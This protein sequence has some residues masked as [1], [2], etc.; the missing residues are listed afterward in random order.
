MTGFEEYAALVRELS[1]RQRGGERAVAAEADRRRGLHA[2]VDQLGHRLAAQGQRLD[3]LG[4]AAG[5]PTP[6]PDGPLVPP[7]SPDGPASQVGVAPAPGAAPGAAPAPPGGGSPVPAPPGGATTT[8]GAPGSLPGTGPVATGGEAAAP[9]RPGV[10]AYPAGT[11]PAPR[12]AEVDPA[13]ELAAARQLVDEA[14]RYGQQAEALAHRSALLPTWSPPARA[15]AVYAVCSLVGS[16]LMLAALMGS[17]I[18]ATGLDLVAAVSCA[19]VPLLSFLAGQLVLGRWGRPPI[20]AGTPPSRYVP[21]GFV[22]CALVSPSLFCVYLLAF[23]L[24]G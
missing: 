22:I 15:V 5:L 17:Q 4:R 12:V 14:D 8:A 19:G 13:A 3:Q 18:P 9:E 20:S 16:V 23:R 10:W 24:I 21:L 7:G 11:V 6:P 1:A 2:A